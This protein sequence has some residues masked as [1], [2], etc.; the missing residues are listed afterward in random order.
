MFIATSMLLIEKFIFR[1]NM[2]LLP[3]MPFFLER[4]LVV[5]VLVLGMR[6]ALRGQG[7]I[8]GMAVA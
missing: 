6:G 7:C 1:W 8:A 5:I 2:G 4:L 3:A